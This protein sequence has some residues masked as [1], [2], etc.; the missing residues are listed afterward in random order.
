MKLFKYSAAQLADA[1][2]RSTSPRHVLLNTN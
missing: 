1:V 2:E